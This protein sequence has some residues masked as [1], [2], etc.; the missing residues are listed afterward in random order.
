M[1]VG[2]RLHPDN[3]TN[4]DWHP[5]CLWLWYGQDHSEDVIADKYGTGHDRAAL[6]TPQLVMGAASCQAKKHTEEVNTSYMAFRRVPLISID[7]SLCKAICFFWLSPAKESAVGQT[8][9]VDH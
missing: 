4:S 1:P 3:L 5:D 9:C 7:T 8:C 6:G 2:C